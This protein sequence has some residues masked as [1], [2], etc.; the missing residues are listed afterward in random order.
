MIRNAR[1]TATIVASQ[2]SNTS[3]QHALA[4][5]PMRERG[6]RDAELH[7]GDEMR[8]G[9]AVICITERARRLPSSA[10]S[11]SRVSRAR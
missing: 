1:S 5:A 11:F 10:S 8:G 3:G 7:R 2:A 6:E 4:E 9:S